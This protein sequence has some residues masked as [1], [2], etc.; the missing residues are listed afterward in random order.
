MAAKQLNLEFT[1]ACNTEM[2]NMDEYAEDCNHYGIDLVHI[3][4]SRN[5]F[6]FKN[7]KAAKQIRA[8]LKNG[9]FDMVHCNTPIG[10]IV[11][12]VC[13]HVEKVKCIIYQAHGFHF[14]KGAPLINWL[15]YYPA[16]RMLSRITDLI[17][18]IT[19]EDYNASLNMHASACRYVH[20]V[21]ID[22]SR[23]K[24][25]VDNDRNI[26]LR[27]LIGIP[28]ENIVL[29]SV[30][31]LN[32][33]KNHKAVIKALSLLPQNDNITYVICGDGPLKEEYK[34]MAVSLGLEKQLKLVGYVSN[35][36]DYYRMSDCFIFPSL[37]EGIPSAI[38][39][40]MAIGVPILASNIRGVCDLINDNSVLF[41]PNDEKEIAHK[42]IQVL[43]KTHSLNDYDDVLD[44]YSL[45]N[46]VSELKTIY[47]YCMNNIR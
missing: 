19:R 40:A 37:R 46:V 22:F 6:S 2:A 1:M 5:P 32:N 9:K 43:S 24:R 20:G 4:F 34:R 15:V 12:R 7:I 30:G 13:A 28:K 16:E 23:F 47:A 36:E 3:D 21:G 8:V 18:T 44:E 33:N 42:I 35:V 26:R 14:W 41:S 29:L 17:I 10:G 27:Q 31:E 39:E 11:G 45:D 38:M 25:R